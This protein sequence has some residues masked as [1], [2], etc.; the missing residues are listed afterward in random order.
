MAKKLVNK[1][2]LIGWDSADWKV[3]N[4]LIQEGKMPALQRLI[5]GGV[6]GNLKTLD[7]PLSPMLWTSIAT[8]VRADKHGIKGFIEPT[9]DG[10]GLRPVT[11]TS[12]KVK[13]IWNILNQENLKSNVV[14]W[15][16]S[17]PAEPINGV[18][19]SNLYQVAGKPIEE[20]W[21][22]PKGTIHPE[23]MTE[24]LKEFRVHPNEI[25]LSMLL[26]F[27]PNLA[28]DEELRKNKRVGGVAKVLAQ[29][30]SV[31]AVS[32][33]LMRT[34]EWDFMAIYHDALDHFSHLTMKFHPPKREHIKEKE[35]E[36]FKDVVE[37]GYRFHDMM[38][39]RTLDLIDENTTVILIS[40]HGFHSDH[41]RPL[42]IPKEP[43]GPAVEHS[44]YGIIVMNGPGIQKGKVISGA[45]VIDITPTLLT[46][47]GLPVGK[48]ME[49]KI[50]LEAFDHVV[51]P[52]YIDSWETVEGKAGMHQEG[53]RED[54]WAAQEALQ[55]LVEL[56]YI[57]AIEDDKL[58]QVEKA[59]R[60]S[61]Y[62]V[63]RNLIDG[64]R[65]DEA[66]SILEEIFEESKIVRYGKRLA[67]VYLAK[68]EFK[69]CEE[70]IEKLKAAE[71][72]NFRK[73]KESKLEKDPDDPFGNKEMEEPMYLEYIEGL[74][75]LSMNKLDRAIPILEKV[76]AKNPAN[77]G[78][79]LAIGK[80]HLNRKN[81]VFAQDQFIKALA[82]DE[83][84]VVAHHGLGL[85]F[86]RRNMLNEAIEELVI[87]IDLNFYFARAH[88]H[89]GEA[90]ARLKNYE[91]AA[92]AFEVAVRIS[93]GMSKAHQWLLE[94]YEK[95]LNE[96]EKAKEHKKFM[97]ENI[98]GEIIVVSGLPRSGTSMMMQMLQ[99]GGVQI[100]SDEIRTADDSNPKGYLEFEKVK[101]LHVDQ[102]WMDEAQG[103]GVKIIAQLLSYLP[104][105]F[106]YKIIM[107]EREMSEVITSQQIM[108]GKEVKE[109]V[110]PL[111]L[112]T[113]FQKQLD[114]ID[115]WQAAQPNVEILKVD[116]ASV[117]EN[118][119]E[120]VQKIAFFLGKE[121]DL[122][123]MKS[124]VEPTLYRN[125][126]KK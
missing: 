43:S 36:N 61:Q 26:P 100:L 62:Y 49:G 97:D 88:Y 52:D 24:E 90:L 69:K 1:V 29:A 64:N 8:G 14:T 4:P 96:P 21:G 125:K 25:T 93:P 31:H 60:E 41:L 30:S 33:K 118:P 44:P 45:S 51:Q 32:T 76:Q 103:K 19:V 9:P 57:E 120:E 86:L 106:T 98:K 82:I 63:A 87:A 2:L 101:R 111:G 65:V 28:E 115:A 10:Q 105:K 47:Y 5:E 72:E 38:L 108:L 6:H 68:G 75:L 126:Q 56:G 124:T 121:L 77:I 122:N 50:L 119:L 46:L 11:S 17:N 107:M 91:E 48:D 12:R 7:P 116:Y 110:L 95:H 74:M 104:E 20:E 15:W 53:E 70:L 22:M 94:I 35:F 42:A 113:A 114:K 80:I 102:S 83:M 37:A 18:M 84:N 54:P 123:A 40:D 78:V 23:G 66:T 117:I 34:T 92:S 79:C 39:E 67:S 89:L 58:A 59:K 81:F 109:G 27:I 99:N 71:I 3:I 13:A 73:L 16:P 112:F 85:S 55:Q